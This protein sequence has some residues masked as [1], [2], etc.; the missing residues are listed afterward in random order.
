MVEPAFVMHW[1]SQIPKVQSDGGASATVFAGTLE[2]AQGLAPPQH[3]WAADAA[4]EVAVWHITIPAGAMFELPVVQSGNGV[5]RAL[6]F[7]EGASL[8]VAGRQLVDKSHVT[9]DASKPCILQNSG[10]DTCEVLVLQGK[11]IAEPIAQHG[12][13][14]MNTQQEIKQAFS[15]YQAT[16]FGGWPWE[17]DAMVFPP[18]QERFARINGQEEKPP[19]DTCMA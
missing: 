8:Q 18:G 14:V 11:P 12:P 13:F 3:S 4:N 10:G 2:G 17:E 16:K 9:L 1:A 6:Y 7:V 19:A 15:D 5:N